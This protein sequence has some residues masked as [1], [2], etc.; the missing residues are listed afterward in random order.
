MAN[1]RDENNQ[2]VLS[3]DAVGLDENTMLARFASKMKEGYEITLTP[4]ET[5]RLVNYLNSLRT[6]F[7]AAVPMLCT[8]E[9]CPFY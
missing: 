1:K 7:Q 5:R 9:T 8:G 2:L 4:K 6:G 3:K